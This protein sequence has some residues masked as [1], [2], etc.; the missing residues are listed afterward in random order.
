MDRSFGWYLGLSEGQYPEPEGQYPEQEAQGR[1][2]CVQAHGI[3]WSLGCH[4]APSR[5]E[6]DPRSPL[7]H[8]SRVT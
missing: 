4:V 8:W 2:V 6:N 7:S 3:V 1:R 5:G